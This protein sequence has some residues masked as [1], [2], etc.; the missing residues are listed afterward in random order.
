MECAWEFGWFPTK[1]AAAIEWNTRASDDSVP[2]LVFNA[3]IQAIASKDTAIK[4][5]VESLDKLTNEIYNYDE[6]RQW[7]SAATLDTCLELLAKHKEKL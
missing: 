7:V 3:S 1:D 5:L 4:E 2:R 6:S